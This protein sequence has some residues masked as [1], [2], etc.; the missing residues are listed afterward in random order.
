MPAAVKH[1]YGPTCSLNVAKNMDLTAVVTAIKLIHNKAVSCGYQCHLTTVS[2]KFQDPICV[3][4]TSGRP[5][6]GDYLCLYWVFQGVKVGSNYWMSFINLWKP[7][8]SKASGLVCIDSSLLQFNNCNSL[9][10]VSAV[11]KDC[12]DLMF[13]QVFN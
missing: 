2:D 6:G 8:K 3:I 5:A 12:L 11:I 10:E 4:K 1:P 9:A 7:D 13:P